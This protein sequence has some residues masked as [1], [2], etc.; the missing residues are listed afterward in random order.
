MEKTFDTSD[1]EKL[2]NAVDRLNVPEETLN[3]LRSIY[4]EVKFTIRDIEGSSSTRTQQTGIRQGCPLSPYL[5]TIVMTVI[6]RDVHDKL[7]LDRGT[8][9]GINF[10]EL[11]YA[12]DTILI[13]NNVN[14]MNRLL[15]KVENVHIITV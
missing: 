1:Q 15:E 11:L 6:F 14:A 4:K 13:T 5:F 8:V 9:D 3:E 2:I 10:T 12:D 7:N